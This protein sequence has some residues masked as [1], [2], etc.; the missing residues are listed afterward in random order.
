MFEEWSEQEMWGTFQI[1]ESKKID[2]SDF[3]VT[4]PKCKKD[5]DINEV[6]H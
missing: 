6:Q 5:F 1:G 2:K 4:C 3:V